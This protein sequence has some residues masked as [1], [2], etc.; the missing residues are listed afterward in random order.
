MLQPQSISIPSSVL[1]AAGDI[2]IS[3]ALCIL[4]HLSRTGLKR[5]PPRTVRKTYTYLFIRTDTM[6]DKLVSGTFPLPPLSRFK[7]DVP[8]MYF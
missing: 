8:S 4:L 6:I 5:W 7:E 3:A 1:A 2:L